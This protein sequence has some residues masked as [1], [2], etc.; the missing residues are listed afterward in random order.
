MGH[1][2]RTSLSHAAEYIAH[3]LMP[4]SAASPRSSPMSTFTHREPSLVYVDRSP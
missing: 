3:A 2:Q 1:T 4:P